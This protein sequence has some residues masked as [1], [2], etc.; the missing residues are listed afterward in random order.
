LPRKS[1]LPRSASRCGLSRRYGQSCEAAMT[2]TR[3]YSDEK[4]QPAF[5]AETDRSRD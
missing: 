1:S 2:R 4:R 5:S 3:T